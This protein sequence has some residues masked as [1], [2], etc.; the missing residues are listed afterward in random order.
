MEMSYKNAFRLWEYANYQ[1]THN[2]TVVRYLPPDNLQQLR[3]LASQQ[4]FNLNGDYRVSGLTVGDRILTIAGQTFA[5]KAVHLLGRTIGSQGATNKLNMLFGSY[6]TFLSFFSLSNL[7]EHSDNFMTLP[8]PGSVMVFELF[9]NTPNN[10]GFPSNEDLWVR[11]LFRNGT[12]PSTRLLS[13]PLFGRGNSA[14]DMPYED[15]VDSM[16]KISIMDVG[17]WCRTCS[18]LATYC[19]S[20]MDNTSNGTNG[21][22]DTISSDGSHAGI[23]AAVAGIIGAIVTLAFLILLLSVA[24]LCFGVRFYRNT[25][26]RQSSLGGFKGAEKLASD[27]DLA[28]KGAAGPSVVRH[29]RVGSW[30]LD[31]AKKAGASR[32]SGISERVVST[33]DYSNKHDEDTESIWGHNRTPVKADEHV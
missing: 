16:S 10:T 30:E 15:F 17:T 22:L 11:F 24:V 1:Y 2:S 27:T 5:G 3:A 18:S 6:E 4:E 29:E 9:S 23:S 26:K 7:Y 13:Y 19:N 14:V 12:D 28:L 32:T 20:F 25:T 33:A 8:E 21:A 31:D